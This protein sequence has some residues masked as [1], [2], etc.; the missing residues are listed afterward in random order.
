MSDVFILEQKPYSGPSLLTQAAI[1]CGT[2]AGLLENEK[3]K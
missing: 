2:I 1:G 3:D